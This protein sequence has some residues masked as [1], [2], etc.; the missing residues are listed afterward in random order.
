MNF[1]EHGANPP[2]DV[3]R[4]PYYQ[5]SAEAQN[6]FRQF[7]EDL[8]SKIRDSDDHPILRE[9][10]SKYRKLM[11]ALALIFHLIDIADGKYSRVDEV[12]GKHKGISVENTTGNKVVEYLGSHA[13]RI[14]KL[15]TNVTLKAALVLPKK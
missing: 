3:F 6:L 5:F 14:Y 9:H 1:I 2:G 15:A 4:F 12:D 11:P 7:D 10:L 13:R 8:E